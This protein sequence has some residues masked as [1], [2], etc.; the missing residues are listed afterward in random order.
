MQEEQQSVD[1]GAGKRPCEDERGFLHGRDDVVE[2]VEQMRLNCE[3]DLVMAM[4]F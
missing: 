3:L 4:R 2:Q 1:R